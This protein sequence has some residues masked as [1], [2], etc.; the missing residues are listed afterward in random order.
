MDN[1]C[2]ICMEY[3]PNILNCIKCNN[4]YCKGCIIKWFVANKT[5]PTCRCTELYKILYDKPWDNIS[6]KFKSY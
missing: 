4:I 3:K 5:C 6:F 2:N 1:Y